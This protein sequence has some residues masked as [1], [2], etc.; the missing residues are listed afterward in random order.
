MTKTNIDAFN[1]QEVSRVHLEPLVVRQALMKK[2]NP[3]IVICLSLTLKFD[4][5]FE[6]FISDKKYRFI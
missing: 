4:L 2:V 5:K 1:Y 6:I 3:K